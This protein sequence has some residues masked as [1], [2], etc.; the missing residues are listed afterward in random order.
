[1][2]TTTEKCRMCVSLCRSTHMQSCANTQETKLIWFS[3]MRLLLQ[4]CWESTTCLQGDKTG[5]IALISS[6][7]LFVILVCF[8]KVTSL[9]QSCE[10]SEEGGGSKQKSEWEEVGAVSEDNMQE[11]VEQQGGQRE[12][13]AKT[14]TPS[15]KP[16]SP[17]ES[18]AFLSFQYSLVVI[19]LLLFS[20]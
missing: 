14:N 20:L 16:A 9:L 11:A 1:M 18:K 15:G 13:P 4:H 6:S 2:N 5:Q 7:R 12:N 19:A 17:A 10:G 8:S 3:V